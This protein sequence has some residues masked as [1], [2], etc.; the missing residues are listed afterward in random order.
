MNFYFPKNLK[1]LCK[2]FVSK[3]VPSLWLLELRHGA[4][5]LQVPESGFFYSATKILL[6]VE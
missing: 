3:S 5:L 6:F 1:I 2:N 4:A